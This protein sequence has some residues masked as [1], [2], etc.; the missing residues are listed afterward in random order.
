MNLTFSQSIKDEITFQEYTNE[1]LKW[2]L[3][4]FFKNNI[5][6]NLSDFKVSWEIKTKSNNIIRFIIK[7]LIKLFNI[8]KHISYKKKST[9]NSR[10]YKLEFTGDFNKL[11]KDLLLFEDPYPLLLNETDKQAFLIGAF[12]SGG[13]INNP[14]SSSYHFEIR[15]HNSDLIDTL[16]KIFND[17]NINSKI[18]N[19]QNTNVIYVKKSESI[20][21]ILK[22]IN[23]YDSMYEYEEKR[24][25]RDYSNQMHRLNNL[26]ISN[27]KKTITA[28]Q[29]QIKWIQK[30]LDNKFLSNQL[31]N[32]EKIFCNL[33]LE[34]P[35]AS[36]NDIANIFLEKYNI[37]ITRTGLNHYV[38]KIKK[39]YTQE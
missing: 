30:V 23:A 39:L 9:G 17:F 36:L 18:L 7:S 8:E 27:L 35:E 22:H 14:K 26:D 2:I 19:R 24:I 3:C 32:K 38:R 10:L 21:D 29:E 12:L 34:N 20:S 16:S 15:S 31:S 28:S 11:E 13:S 25:Y 4:S 37:E 33:R 5:A 1:Q 6:I